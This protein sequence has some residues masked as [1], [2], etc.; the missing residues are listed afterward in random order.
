MLLYN[1]LVTHKNIIIIINLFSA[2]HIITYKC[3]TEQQRKAAREATWL[4]EL[5]ACYSVKCYW[6]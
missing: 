6:Q 1:L 4:D 2:N 3:L 5:A